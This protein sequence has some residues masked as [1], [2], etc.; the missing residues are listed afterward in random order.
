MRYE[1][2]VV[3]GLEELAEREVRQ[4][5][6]G[7]VVLG[8]PAEGRVSIRF[9]GDPRHLA[10]LRTAVAVYLVEAFEVARPRGLLGHQ[11]FQRVLG[12]LRG[13][14]A[15]WPRDAFAT[16][17]LSA[18]GADTATFRRF[19]E[20]VAE[21]IGIP[22]AEGASDL[23]VIV[24]RPPEGSPGWEVLARA[25]PRPLSAR[26]WRVCDLPGALNATV[27]SAMASLTTPSR[28]DRFLNV[29]CGSG[30]LLIERLAL[31]PARL[32]VGADIDPNA[33]RCAQENV[34][35]SGNS[36]RI[37]FLLADATR[38]PLPNASVDAVVADLPYG[39]LVGSARLNER[40]YPAVV[41]EAGRVAAPGARLVVITA[42]RKL[43]ESALA[44]NRPLWEVRTVISLKIPS[45]AGYLRPSIYLA[46]RV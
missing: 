16:F 5:L 25:S 26:A 7:A 15:S 38:L 27:A 39:M 9:D 17:H 3:A 28:N 23:L 6:P 13:V 42:S 21:G 11:N 1:V 8:R 31:G 33:L 34:R 24:R 19:K 30:T 37:T 40:L 14:V 18:A 29:A 35:A 44:R 41:E 45:R 12:A 43:F 2:E 20:S 4:R 22:S 36:A 32:A 46:R 10:R